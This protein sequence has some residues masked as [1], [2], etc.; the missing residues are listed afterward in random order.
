MSDNTEEFVGCG[1]DCACAAKRAKGNCGAVQADFFSSVALASEILSEPS[2]EFVDNVRS[3]WSSLAPG[4]RVFAGGVKNWTPVDRMLNDWFC[5]SEVTI[6]FARSRYGDVFDGANELRGKLESISDLL[7]K[8]APLYAREN[9]LNSRG[10]K[11]GVAACI[12]E[13]TELIKSKLIPSL[14]LSPMEE[15]ILCETWYRPAVEWTRSLAFDLVRDV[16]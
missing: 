4:N 7:Y 3:L 1:G 12:N 5:S 15:S 11:A 9:Y 16:V 14:V 10:D 13:R 2:D 6:E 8:I